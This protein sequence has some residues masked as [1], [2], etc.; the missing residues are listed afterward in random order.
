MRLFESQLLEHVNFILPSSG[1]YSSLL[2]DN[3]PPLVKAEASLK[4]VAS[5][6]IKKAS[7]NKKEEKVISLDESEVNSI[8]DAGVQALMMIN[9]AKRVELLKS[10]TSDQAGLF[11]EDIQQ[12]RALSKEDDLNKVVALI[13]EKSIS[14]DEIRVRLAS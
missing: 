5:E 10:L 11:I 13:R 3:N 4:L 1:I 14:L 9:R 7:K 2:K 6:Q 12:A 8:N